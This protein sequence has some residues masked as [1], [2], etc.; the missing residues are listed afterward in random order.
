MQGL[1]HEH[2]L[3]RGHGLLP[4]PAGRA[5][6]PDHRGVRRSWPS[7]S[8]NPPRIAGRCSVFAKSDMIHLQQNATPVDDIVAGLCFALARNFKGTVA[9]GRS[10]APPVAFQGG[11]AANAGMVRAFREV[12]EL[13]TNCSSPRAFRRSWAPSGAA[14]KARTRTARPRS[15][16]KPWRSTLRGRRDVRGRTRRRS[17]RPATVP[18]STPGGTRAT[19]SSPREGRTGRSTWAS[20]SAPSAPTSRSSTSSGRLL[21]SAT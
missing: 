7:Q 15:G 11:V 12:L 14:L 19:S 20:T 1:R 9:R 21:P 4:R 13:S 2:R 8:Q 3:R 16:S 18:R 5:A 17:C 6:G 10:I